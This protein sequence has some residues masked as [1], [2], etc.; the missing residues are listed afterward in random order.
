MKARTSSFFMPMMSTTK[1]PIIT[2]SGKP[3]KA[4][5][6]IE[7]SSDFVSANVSPR[8]PRIP[9]RMPNDNEVTRSAKQ[10]ATKSLSRCI[11]VDMARVFGLIL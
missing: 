6:V 5:A 2:A 9:A 4:V 11:V 7:A 8:V 10:E 3:Q 1:P